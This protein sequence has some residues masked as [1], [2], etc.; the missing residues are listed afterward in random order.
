M[1]RHI[2]WLDDAECQRGD[3]T[4]G[5]GA[6]LARMRGAGIRVPPGFVVTVDA[7]RDWLT[8]QGVIEEVETLAASFPASDDR[9]LPD[10]IQRL[11]VATVPDGDLADEITSAYV[12]LGEN[13]SVAVRSSA[14]AEDGEQASFAGQQETF[15]NVVGPEDVL[16]KVTECWAS[17]FSERALFYRHVKGTPA[18]GTGSDTGMAVVVQ[19]QIASDKSGVILTIDP[20][21]RRSDQMI[22][23]AGF[24]LGEALVSGLIIPDH[25]MAR[26]DG[27]LKKVRVG[28]QDRMIVQD[29]SGGTATVELEAAAATAQV[30]NSTEIARLVSVGLQL[31]EEFGSPQD[32]EWAIAA[33]ELF[34]LQSRPITA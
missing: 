25:Y 28:R 19:T 31:E 34:I 12:R 6:N 7:L 3:I 22:I 14:C 20:I 30:L 2:V 27:T 26:R 24:G 16:Q 9:D 5:K 13:A 10:R 8:K 4:G 33:D 18:K 1:T 11:V 15:L 23:E 29:H 21:R 17:F 32:I